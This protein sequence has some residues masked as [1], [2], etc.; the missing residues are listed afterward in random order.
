MGEF[1]FKLPPY[2][3]QLDCWRES[4]DLTN[5]AL[6]L[7]MGC[8]D[9]EAEIAVNRHGHQYKTTIA[10]AYEKSSE[11]TTIS[12]SDG[13]F[14]LN[15]IL[16]ILFSG[17]KDTLLLEFESER[18][19]AVTEDHEVLTDRGWVPAKNLCIGQDSAISKPW[20]SRTHWSEE[21]E[22]YLD[23]NG[24]VRSSSHCKY[25]RTNIDRPNSW[26]KPFRTFIPELDRLIK[27]SPGGVRAVYDMRMA[28]PYH[29]FLAN[30]I[31]VHNCG[32]TKVV[33]DV[34]GHLAMQNKINAHVVIAPKSVYRNWEEVEIPKHLT[35]AVTNRSA[36][37]VATPK[38]KDR[39]DLAKLHEPGNDLKTL[40][41][42]VEAMSTERGEEEVAEFLKRH[43]ALMTVDE[44][45][46]IKNKDAKRTKTITDLGKL[47]KYRRICSGNPMPNGPL[48]LFSQGEFLQRN[49]MGYGNY[50]AFRNR[51]AVMQRLQFGG[52]SFQKVV[53]YRDLDALKQAMSR[54]A[55]ILKKADCPDIDLPPKVYETMDVTMGPRQTLAYRQMKEEAITCLEGL[56]EVTAQIVITQMMRLHQIACG[57]LKPETGGEVP[58]DEP[59]DRLDTLMDV[60]EQAPGKVIIWATYRYNVRQILERIKSVYGPDSV[61]DYFGDTTDDGRRFAKTEFQ[62]PESKVRFIVSNPATGKWGN[63]WTQGTTVVYYSNSYDLEARDQ[64]E[65]RSHRIGQAGAI[66]AGGTTPSVLY[67]DLRVRGTVDEKIIRVLHG[68]KKLSDEIISSNWKWL[69]GRD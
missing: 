47:A 10:E 12:I 4:K 46:T 33:L 54:W 23:T 13:V 59:N 61:V 28:D 66:H 68:K 21:K 48:D 26:L 11:L 16:D 17:E 18:T 5:H 37:W 60:L 45:T 22:K 9:G 35:D 2:K 31:V 20:S 67:V 49:I 27:K 30:G 36:C 8:V 38:K 1:P 40:I 7:D 41:V 65:D 44:S 6:F 19:L 53:G 56:P 15:T 3:H 55:F 69:L 43:Q 62:D 25:L 34:A 29:N 58:F 51:F 50:Y 52:R 57:F 32:K 14:I 63:T 64:S 42:N 24:Y 39:E